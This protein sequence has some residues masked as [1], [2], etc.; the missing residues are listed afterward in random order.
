M[1]TPESLRGPH[2]SD[3]KDIAQSTFTNFS[4]R[5]IVVKLWLSKLFSPQSCHHRHSRHIPQ[6]NIPKNIKKNLPIIFLQKT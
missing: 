1:A 4:G 2:R 6:N 5:V 3:P